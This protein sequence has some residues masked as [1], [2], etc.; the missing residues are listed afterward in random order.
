MSIFVLTCRECGRV[1]V[2]DS[3]AQVAILT[4]PVRPSQRKILDCRCGAYQFAPDAT[5]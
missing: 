1:T 5:N 2:L 3:A 4:D